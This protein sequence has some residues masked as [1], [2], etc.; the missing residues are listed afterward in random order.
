MSINPNKTKSSDVSNLGR[1]K[2]DSGVFGNGSLKDSQVFSR[3]F[4]SFSREENF[5]QRAVL[6]SANPKALD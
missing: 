3:N 1:R 4:D 5:N 6:S 2:L